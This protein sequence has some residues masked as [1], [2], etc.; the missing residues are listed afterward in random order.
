MIYKKLIIVLLFANF[1]FSAYGNDDGKSKPYI[2]GLHS[3][4]LI[5]Q[6]ANELYNDSKN[7]VLNNAG[8]PVFISGTTSFQID[9]TKT[10]KQCLLKLD[11]DGKYYQLNCKD[12][13]DIENANADDK[14]AIKVARKKETESNLLSCINIK[15]ASGKELTS[16]DKSFQK[17]FEDPKKAKT[18]FQFGGLTHWVSQFTIG[19]KQQ[20]DFSEEKTMVDGQEK[21][22]YTSKGLTKGTLVASLLVDGRW[23]MVDRVDQSHW[24]DGFIFNFGS[25]VIFGQSPSYKPTG[26]ATAHEG[27]KFNNVSGSVDAYVKFIAS[28][29]TNW[30]NGSTVLSFGGLYGARSQDNATPED[31]LNRYYG[32][33]GELRYYG[34]EI[35]ANENFLPIFSASAYR[36]KTES[37]GTV[38]D[39]WVTSL[40]VR[41][42][43][44]NDYDLLLGVDATLGPQ[45]ADDVGVLIVYRKSVGDLLGFF[46]PAS[47]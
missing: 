12:T 37:W 6:C 26:E 10:D 29:G 28:P 18:V 9:T 43:P 35:S 44:L 17:K 14:N 22:I 3:Q 1:A 2:V 41:Y 23:S 30:G 45:G 11:T 42:K 38:R 8:A 15:V 4:S 16:E 21:T 31:Q 19:Y 25:G 40:H 39:K 47:K 27:A 13:P 33:G 24:L 34:R 36:L 46:N 7:A 32:G 5:G 20:N